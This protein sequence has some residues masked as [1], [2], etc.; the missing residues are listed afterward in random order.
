VRHLNSHCIL[1][2][3]DFVNY[4]WRIEMKKT[5]VLIIGSEGAGARAAIQ[6]HDQGH[7]ALIITKGR[8]ARSGATITAGMDIDMDS[9]SAKELLG[10]AGDPA[11]SPEI[12]FEDMVVEGRFINNQKIVEAHVQEAPQRIKEVV[13]WGME[14]VGFLHG[15]GHRYP[16]GVY[17]SGGELMKA[18]R[19]EVKARKIEVLE[20]V[21]ALDF[22]KQDGRVNGILCLDLRKGEFFTVAAKTFIVA[23]GGGMRLF[24]VTTAPEELTGDGQA[25]AWRAGADLIDMEMVQFLPC[26]FITPPAWSGITFPFFMGPGVGGVDAWLLNK[27]GNRF[28]SKWDPENME[29]T[30]RDILSIAVMNEVVEGRGSPNGGVFYSIKHLPDNLI[31]YFPI[32]RNEPYLSPNWEFKGFKLKGFMEEMKRGYACEVGPACHFFMGGIRVNEN[33]QTTVPGLYACGEV[34]GGTHGGNRLTGNACTQIL[35]QGYRAGDAAAKEAKV[36]PE[37]VID[38]DQI[39]RLKK[40]FLAPLEAK[41]GISSFSMRKRLQTLAWEKV[42]VLRTGE[43][44]TEALKTI[45]NLKE[46]IPQIAVKAKEPRYNREWIEA[47]QV[48]NLLTLLEAI[49]RSAL[50]REESRG[51]HYRRDFPEMGDEKWLK[52][53]V[54]KNAQGKTQ[55]ET[56]PI[57]I[58][59][60]DP[61]RRGQ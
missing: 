26:C 44:L 56:V 25:M 19:K 54:I 29:R 38:Q 47:L 52:N 5:D 15:P 42:G 60:Y 8:F 58:T 53:V 61:R 41:D 39:E 11:D 12:F 51:A 32:W 35:V 22:L 57:V 40:E 14:V 36:A 17:S 45:G 46:E 27:F 23:T 13:D 30:T 10:L 34:A 6:V 37:P 31:D 16:R 2:E 49:A 28:M 21:M 33:G 55:V 4:T 3:K 7:H 59:S 9:R 43:L 50:S 48:G 20:D 1:Y 18:L 24:P